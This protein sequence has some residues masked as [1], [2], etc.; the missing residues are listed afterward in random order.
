MMAKRGEER[1][2]KEFPE[3][4]KDNSVICRTA[5]GTVRKEYRTSGLAYTSIIM[6]FDY[7]L[8][9]GFK[10]MYTTPTAPPMIYLFAKHGSI[11]VAEVTYDEKDEIYSLSNE[12]IKKNEEYLKTFRDMKPCVRSVIKD[13]TIKSPMD[14]RVAKL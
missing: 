14:N 1:A 7:A 3:Y 12:E 8:Q 9:M 2:R 11:T 13:V 4:F 10:Y 6:I 5:G